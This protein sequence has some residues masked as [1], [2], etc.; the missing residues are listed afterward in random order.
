MSNVM[1][2]KTKY[3]RSRPKHGER[4][5][6]TMQVKDYYFIIRF[7]QIIFQNRFPEKKL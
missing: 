2:R 5:Y 7:H 6:S 3:F 1:K 4:Y